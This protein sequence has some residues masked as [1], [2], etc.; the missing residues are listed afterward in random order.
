MRPAWAE[1]RSLSRAVGAVQ[2]EQHGHRLRLSHAGPGAGPGEDQSQHQVGEREQG[3]GAPV[4]Q[5]QQ[6][7]V[8]GLRSRLAPL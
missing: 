5:R 7:L 1:T 4:V 2:E 3:G 8:P 6:Q